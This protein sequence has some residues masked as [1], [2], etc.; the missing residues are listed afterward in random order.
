MFNKHLFDKHMLKACLV[1]VFAIGLAACSSSDSG[2]DTSMPTEPPTTPTTPTEPSAPADLSALFA[3]AQ[4][5]SDDAAQAGEDATDAQMSATESADMLTTMEVGGDSAKAMMNAQAILDAMDAAIQAVKDAEAALADAKQAEMDAM[6]IADEHPQKAALMA[7]V[8]DAIMAAEAQVEAT[9]MVRDGR[10]LDDAVYEVTG[11]GGKGTP[12]S[13]ANTVGGDIAGALAQHATNARTGTRTPAHAA[14]VG[15]DIAAALKHEAND[16]QGMTWAMIAGEANV[17]DMRLGA[18]TSDD[19]VPGNGILSVASIAGMDA[20]AVD[21]TTTAVLSATGGTNSDGMYADGASPGLATAGT[22]GGT[23]YMGIPGVVVCLGGDDGCSVSSAG[24]LSAGWYFSPTSPMVYYIRNTDRTT[25]EAMPYVPETLY[26]SYGYWLSSNAD[27]S[28]WTV[29]TFSSVGVTATLTTYDVAANDDLAESA[30]Y[31]GS[32]AGMSVRTMGSGDS[33][34][35]DSGM[36][37]ADVMLTATFGA[38]PTL[39]GTIN[40]FQGDAVGSSWSVKLQSAT[41][42]AGGAATEGVATA[43]GHSGSWSNQAYGGADAR[44]TGIHGGFVAH[45]ADGDAAGAYA[46]RMDP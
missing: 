36:F 40:N 5:A 24:K 31:S 39:E 41:L 19:L 6:A 20:S 18:I 16:A 17:M 35:T 34:T 8:D 9:K 30:T 12:R 22:T 38:S 33:K 1:A 26:A 28:E 10:D 15:T 44:P 32:A 14:A 45:F 11:M 23:E 25:S 37:T 29:N 7:A 13:I 4:D 27:A 2:T 43:G 21:K 3:A 46:A 42:A